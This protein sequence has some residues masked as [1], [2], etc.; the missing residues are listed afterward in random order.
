MVLGGRSTGTL[1]IPGAIVTTVGL[2]LF[3]QNVFDRFESWAYAW[4]LIVVAVGIGMSMSGVWSERPDWV[5]NG[6]G[7]TR[8]GFVLF[9]AGFIFFEFVLNIGG[10]GNGVT[11]R[12]VAPLL[13]IGIGAYA[14]LRGL[15]TARPA[16][17]TT[18]S[19]RQ[20]GDGFPATPDVAEAPTSVQ[21][22]VTPP[23][24]PPPAQTKNAETKLP[25]EST[26]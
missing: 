11:G 7:L 25:V 6:W 21:K 2:I 22:L 5:R 23:F 17:T 8:I 3:Y 26:R 4:A 16:P 13:L 20:T 19:A 9:A 1:A 12:V 18:L 24:V 14:L 15:G 10:L